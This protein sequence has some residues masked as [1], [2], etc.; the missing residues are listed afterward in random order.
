MTKASRDLFS[1]PLPCDPLHAAGLA[2]RLEARLRAEMWG[3]RLLAA[4]SLA[5]VLLSLFSLPEPLQ[6]R[7]LYAALLSLSAVGALA[8]SL[9]R[10]REARAVARLRGRLEQGYRPSWLCESTVRDLLR[11]ALRE[12]ATEPVEEQ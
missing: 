12:A 11:H 5:G 9:R 4:L 2:A 3:G 7:L 8:Y 1:L 10:G 6:V